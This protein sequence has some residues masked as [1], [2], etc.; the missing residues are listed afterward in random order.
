MHFFHAD[1]HFS[2]DLKFWLVYKNEDFLTWLSTACIII[3]YLNEAKS[4]PWCHQKPALKFILD[5][6][7]NSD[8]QTVFDS[9]TFTS[10]N[11]VVFPFTIN[12]QSIWN[13]LCVWCEFKVKFFV[14]FFHTDVQFSLCP[15]NCKAPIVTNQVITYVWVF[16]CSLS[17]FM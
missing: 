17:Y 5:L 11:S 4:Y 1:Q 13:W 15:L 7:P 6:T 16:L 9:P 2:T 8:A 12:P 14:L 3:G 10:R